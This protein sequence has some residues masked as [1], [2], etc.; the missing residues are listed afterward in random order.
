VVV[1]RATAAEVQ[2]MDI[3]QASVVDQFRLLRLQVVEAVVMHSPEVLEDL[4]VEDPMLEALL[5]LELLDRDIP[6]V[7]LPVVAVVVQVVRAMA[8]IHMVVEQMVVLDV[9]GLIPVTTMLVE[10]P[11][12]WADLEARVAEVL[13]IKITVLQDVKIPEEVEVVSAIPVTSGVGV[14]L[15]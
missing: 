5:V 3:L 12:E 8:D 7:H 14:D 13:L 15:E 10:E 4:E 2:V 11:L 1:L 6:E 9:F